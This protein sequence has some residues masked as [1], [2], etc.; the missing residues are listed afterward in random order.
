MDCGQYLRI[1]PTEQGEFLA[2]GTTDSDGVVDVEAAS[3]KDQG[4]DAIRIPDGEVAV[5]LRLSD[6]T[7]TNFVPLEKL[8]ETARA[9]ASSQ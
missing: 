5:G 9:T 7:Y 8:A 1:I 2:L 6:G 4:R 3:F